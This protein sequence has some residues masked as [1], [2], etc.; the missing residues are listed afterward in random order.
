HISRSHHLEK[1]LAAG[2]DDVVHMVVDNLPAALISE[3]IAQ[4][5]YWVPT[6]ELWDGVSELHRVNWDA[7]AKNNLS[8]FVSA[9]GKVALGT[10]FDGYVTDFQLGL[11]MHE[12]ELMQA[13]GMTPMQ[14]IVAGTRNAAHVCNLDT[15]LGTIEPG[16]IA[17]ILVVAGNPLEDLQVLRNV[18]LVMH[19]G[20]V[21]REETAD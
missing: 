5:M 19:N 8:R 10:D 18:R 20:E 4:D 16:K 3:M 7:Q 2:V 21:I 14:I 11:P 9:G 12:M 13:A 15:V 1:A 6:L 17:D